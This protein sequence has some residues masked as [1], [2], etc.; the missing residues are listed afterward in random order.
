MTD[1]SFLNSRLKVASLGMLSGL[2]PINAMRDMGYAL[3][4]FELIFFVSTFMLLGVTLAIATRFSYLFYY[5]L[6]LFSYAV[7]D[8]NFLEHTKL[9]LALAT[10]SFF[11]FLL[12]FRIFKERT[13]PYIIVFSFVFM[14]L[15]LVR[16]VQPVLSTFGEVIYSPDAPSTSILHIVLDEMGSPYNVSYSPPA[17]HPVARMFAD[18]ESWGFAVNSQVYSRYSSTINSLSS[19]AA[20]APKKFTVFK[21]PPSAAY[22]YAIKNN[23]YF[24]MLA[25]RHYSVSVLQSSYLDHCIG[26]RKIKCDTYS[27]TGSGNAFGYS[28]FL[29]RIR[30]TSG[31]LRGAFSGQH[32]PAIFFFAG[33]DRYISGRRPVLQSYVPIIAE[34]LLRKEVLTMAESIKPGHAYYVHALF[35]HFP[36]LFDAECN[37]IALENVGLPQRHSSDHDNETAYRRYWDQVACA[38]YLV[39]QIVRGTADKEFLTTIIHGDHGPRIYWQTKKENRDDQTKTFVAV[40]GPNIASGRIDD[41]KLLQDVVIKYLQD[42]LETE[43][44]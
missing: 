28:G 2:I 12:V 26:S 41:E 40:R 10:I 11:A 5:V 24:E 4:S 17:D 35:P 19:I 18:Y 42:L 31:A 25:E 37:R 20:L 6:A 16:P 29:E 15:S 38:H 1:E 7:V 36:Y 21:Q 39:E 32:R 33:V 13:L 9:N 34:G 3:M 27:R 30:F 23:S 22:S 43:A 14:L 44:K 8:T